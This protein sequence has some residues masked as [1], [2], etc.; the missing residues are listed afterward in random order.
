[1][2]PE[3]SEPFPPSWIIRW[4]PETTLLASSALEIDF[5]HAIQ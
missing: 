4:S 5:P 3:L 2:G 1:M